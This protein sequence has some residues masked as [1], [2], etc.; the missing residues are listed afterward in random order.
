MSGIKPL[1]DKYNWIPMMLGIMR[2][3][4]ISIADK[5]VIEYFIDQPYFPILY[6]QL[7]VG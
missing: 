6:D 5:D 3:N 4:N 2:S 7:T 1:Y